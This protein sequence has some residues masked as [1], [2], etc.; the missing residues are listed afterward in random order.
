MP[1]LRGRVKNCLT[2]VW[3]DSCLEFCGTEF[4]PCNS[5]AKDFQDCFAQKAAN[6]RVY[7]SLIVENKGLI[8]SKID[9]PLYAAVC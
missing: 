7:P 9:V 2:K 6:F 5:C 3:H 1:R 8:D 4:V